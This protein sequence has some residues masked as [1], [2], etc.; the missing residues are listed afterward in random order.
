[1]K[2]FVYREGC[3]RW[4]FLAS[5]VRLRVLETGEG[6]AASHFLTGARN[7]NRQPHFLMP[8]C[9][10]VRCEVVSKAAAKVELAPTVPLTAEKVFGV[11]CTLGGIC[12]PR[13]AYARRNMLVA[14]RKAQIK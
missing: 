12:R 7:P 1:M 11:G 6:R 3:E 10:P 9:P 2:L 4:T 8:R 5:T 13:G 14:L